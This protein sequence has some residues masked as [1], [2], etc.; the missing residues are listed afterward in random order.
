M[1]QSVCQ[2]ERNRHTFPLRHSLRTRKQDICIFAQAEAY[3]AV[4]SRP[5]LRLCFGK[6]LDYND[7]YVQRQLTTRRVSVLGFLKRALQPA[8]SNTRMAEDVSGL[9]L[10]FFQDCLGDMGDII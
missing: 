1:C 7:G 2:H 4:Q 6:N 5:S 10:R 8:G 3:T 9:K